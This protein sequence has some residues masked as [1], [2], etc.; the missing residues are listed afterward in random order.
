M[1]GKDTIVSGMAGRYANALFDLAKDENAV[2]AV[3]ADFDALGGMI[4]ESEDLR[5]LIK[6]PVFSA[7]EQS[8]AIGAV[9]D[10]AG[11]SPLTAKFVK[12]VASNRRLFAVESMIKGF[13][14]LAAADRGATTAEV[15]V[16]EALTD[17]RR[18]ALAKALQDVTGKTVDFDVKVDPKILGGLIVR[19]GSRM[20]DASLKTKLNSIKL[21]MK[22]VG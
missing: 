4:A 20:V 16:A 17:D 15:T 22:E 1:A 3:S 18:S 11:A 5:R 6:S 10:H 13:R 19:L 14:A 8:K 9:L 21:A 2:D 12:L 7:D